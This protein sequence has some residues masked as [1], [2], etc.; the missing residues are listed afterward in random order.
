[1]ERIPLRSDGELSHVA[2]TV[3]RHGG[4]IWVDGV[5]MLGDSQGEIFAEL[6]ADE[7]DAL[8]LALQAGAIKARGG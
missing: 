3:Y 2:V 1:M 7:A 8:A 4:G 6:E 5:K